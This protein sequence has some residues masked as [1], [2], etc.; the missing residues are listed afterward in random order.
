[1]SGAGTSR[2]SAGQAPTSDSTERTASAF[3]YVHR[4]TPSAAAIIPGA[5]S[6]AAAA[7]TSRNVNA[8]LVGDVRMGQLLEDDDH[9]R[10]SEGNQ[11]ALFAEKLESLRTGLVGEI[12]ADDWMYEDSAYAGGG[13]G[14]RTAQG[15]SHGGGHHGS[16]GGG[17]S[18]YTFVTTTTSD[19]W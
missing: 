10:C 3:Q 8:A 17:S 12:R 9:R 14:T 1:M 16:G 7:G 5:T 11:R 19:H 18:N 13:G 4:T 2:G 15:G 6:G